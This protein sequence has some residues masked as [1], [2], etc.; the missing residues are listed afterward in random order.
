MLKK[1]K[2]KVSLCTAQGVYGTVK[3]MN[4]LRMNLDFIVTDTQGF[5]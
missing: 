4:E 2:V 5:N 3:F 1:R